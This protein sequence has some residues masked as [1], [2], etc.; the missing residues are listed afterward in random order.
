MRHEMRRSQEE[1]EN[2]F[3]PINLDYIFQ[4]DDPLVPWIE[5]RENPLLEEVQNAKWLPIVDSDDENM[6]DGGD[7]DDGTNSNKNSGGGGLSPPSNNNGN[8]GDNAEDEKSDNEDD[9][10]DGRQYNDPY[11]EIPYNRRDAS[12]VVDMTRYRSDMP[13]NSSL[14][15]N[16]RTCSQPKRG[17]RQQ[18]ISNQEYSTSNIEEGFSEVSINDSAQSSTTRNHCHIEGFYRRIWYLVC[19]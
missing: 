19:R 14:A 1:I 3:N 16:R 10:N 18:D 4:D 6:E 8:G 12:L 5:E 17:K 2:S 11:Q 7:D 13:S 15:D 9:D